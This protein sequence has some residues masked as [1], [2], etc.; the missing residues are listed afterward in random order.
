[1]GSLSSLAEAVWIGEAIRKHKHEGQCLQLFKVY[2]IGKQAL[3][4]DRT[5]FLTF[6]MYGTYST[7]G[8]LLRLDSTYNYTAT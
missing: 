1:M 5:V 3:G 2:C 6:A 7:S 8:A 4:S